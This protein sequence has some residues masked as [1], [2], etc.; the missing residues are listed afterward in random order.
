MVMDNDSSK[1]REGCKPTYKQTKGFQPLHICWGPY[2]IDVI[3][4]KGSV[5]LN[6]VTDYIDSVTEI[7]NQIRT[8]YSKEVPIVLCADS[9]FADQK[10]YTVFE[11]NLKINY[12]PA[13]DIR[14]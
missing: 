7:V 12:V 9:G 2:L 10:A 6:H 1:K 3:F 11:D 4:Q 14:I 8:K 13:F 5:H